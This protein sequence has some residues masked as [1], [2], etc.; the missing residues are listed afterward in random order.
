MLWKIGEKKKKTKEIIC[1]PLMYS[2][3]CRKTNIKRKQPRKERKRAQKLFFFRD[4]ADFTA[5]DLFSMVR[6]SSMEEKEKKGENK[7]KI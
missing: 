3:L 5:G 7:E 4:K 1:F 2:Y 6:I